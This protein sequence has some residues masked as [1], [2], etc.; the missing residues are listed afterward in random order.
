MFVSR[1][2]IAR[3]KLKTI[4]V[5][6][7]KSFFEMKSTCAVVLAFKKIKTFSEVQWKLDVAGKVLSKYAPCIVEV[8]DKIPSKLISYF[9]SCKCSAE[10]KYVNIKLVAM[11]VAFRRTDKTSMV[12]PVVTGRKFTT[13]LDSFESE[14][15]VLSQMKWI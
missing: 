11:L 6:A 13:G 5:S 10:M 8:I 4:L 15:L 12:N 2:A 9:H 7:T 1:A 3:V 14:M